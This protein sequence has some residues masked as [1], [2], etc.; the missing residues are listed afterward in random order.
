M[1]S[2]RT[3]AR[4]VGVLFI[5]ASAAA[6]VGG[7]LLIPL[8][9]TDYLAEVTANGA[10]VVSGVIIE[11]I[12]VLSVIGIGVMLYPMLRR[13][14]EG[15]ALGYAGA[16]MLE[17]VAL[18]T[19]SMSAL[20]VFS[21]GDRSAGA[22]GAQTIGDSFLAVRDWTYL[23]GSMVLL[24]VSALVLNSLL[25]RSRLVPAWI[26]LWGVAGGLL[27]LARGIIEM[28][29]WD[30]S[31]L[32]QGLLAAPIAIQEMVLAIWLI[33]RG[34]DTSRLTPAVPPPVEAARDEELV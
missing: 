14:N 24:G 2:D 1:M 21:V 18:F 27:I 17:S 25:Y 11:I 5:L 28:Y 23:V 20:V 31:G 10:Q 22:V 13:R 4:V 19:A 33:A 6:I 29:G 3:I 34:F 12:L 32:A 7:S 15:L 16:R 26:S 30:P 9:D 8:D